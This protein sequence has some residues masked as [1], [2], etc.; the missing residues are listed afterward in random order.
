MGEQNYKNH[1]RYILFWHIITPAIILALNIGSARNW[2]YSYE[3]NDYSAALILALSLVLWIFY[4]Y[5][6]AFALRAQDRAI[7]AEENFRHF[8]ITGKP[9]DRGLRMSQIIALRFA[10]DAEFPALA[11]KALNEKLTS[12]QIKLAIKDWKADYNRV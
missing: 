9:L 4:W 2:Y 1:P 10:S 5:A 6:R 12:K 3:S 8:I 7:R 11:Q